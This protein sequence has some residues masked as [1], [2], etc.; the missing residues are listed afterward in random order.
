M[1]KFRGLLTWKSLAHKVAC[2]H[3]HRDLVFLVHKLIYCL[4]SGNVSRLS[5]FIFEEKRRGGPNNRAKIGIQPTFISGFK[6]RGCPPLR[7]GKSWRTVYRQG[8]YGWKNRGQPVT[9][10]REFMA[11]ATMEQVLFRYAKK[12]KWDK[13][14]SPRS[15]FTRFIGPI[16]SR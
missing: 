9:H 14:G 8:V 11:R 1:T 6:R 3:A 5:S 15:G 12:K 16:N 13:N 2:I 4:H 10:A 7:R